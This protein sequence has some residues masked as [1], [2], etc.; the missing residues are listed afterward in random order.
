MKLKSRQ[1]PSGSS[2]HDGSGTWHR[3]CVHLPYQCCILFG[4]SGPGAPARYLAGDLVVCARC[5]VCMQRSSFWQRRTSYSCRLSWWAHLKLGGSD[6]CWV[7]IF[8]VLSLV[9]PCR[10]SCSDLSRTP[11]LNL[12]SALAQFWP[13]STDS[14]CASLND[15]HRGAL[16]EAHFCVRGNQGKFTRLRLNCPGGTLFRFKQSELLQASLKL[17]Q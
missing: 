2:C 12:A 16:E 4:W 3:C 1:T 5:G 7:F 17:L 6:L 10:M 9:Y 11:V 8:G 15:N 13:A 14:Q